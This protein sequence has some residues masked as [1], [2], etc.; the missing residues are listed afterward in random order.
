M[1]NLVWSD[2]DDCYLA[3]FSEFPGLITHGDTPEEAAA[4]AEIAAK[5]F[6]EIYKE[7]GDTDIKLKG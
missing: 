3:T 4:E 5:G 6:I 2:E 7:D 1:K